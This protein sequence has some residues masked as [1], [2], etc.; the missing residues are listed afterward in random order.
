MLLVGSLCTTHTHTHIVLPLNDSSKMTNYWCISHIHIQPITSLLSV[1]TCLSID[2]NVA[3]GNHCYGQLLLW[4]TIVM[5]NHCYGQPL[6]W[7]TVAIVNHCRG[8][9]FL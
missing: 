8:Q 3:M 9:L 2:N 4:A 7:A 5:D 6:L 1:S